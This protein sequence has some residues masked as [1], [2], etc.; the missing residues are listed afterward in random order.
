MRHPTLRKL[1]QIA[2]LVRRRVL[3]QEKLDAFCEIY[4]VDSSNLED[5]SRNVAAYNY[6]R[7]EYERLE[8]S[9]VESMSRA[10]MI[11]EIQQRYER[12]SVEDKL[13]S[14]D[15]MKRRI[16]KLAQDLRDAGIREDVIESLIGD[17]EL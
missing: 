7:R 15:A 2:D 3:I 5:I 11:K 6:A 12:K 8:R 1:R 10:Q 9:R 13:L 16:R 17:Q 14:L 4:D